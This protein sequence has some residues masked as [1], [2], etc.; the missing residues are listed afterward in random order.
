MAPP[1]LARDAPVADVV[2][3][4]EVGLG[5]ILGDELDAAGFDHRDGFF[6]ERL[7]AHEPLRGDERLDHRLAAVALADGERVRLDLFEQAEALEVFDHAAACFEAVETGVGTGFGGHSAVL[8]DDLDARQVV[9][10]AGFEIVGIVGGSDFDGAGA[11]LGVGEI[12]EDHG[13]LAIH[14]GQID[15]AAVQVEL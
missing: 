9:T 5:P 4:L 7:G 13:D 8:V 14:Q 2:H 12:V 6:G 10:L 15:G 3:P 11:E 1:Q